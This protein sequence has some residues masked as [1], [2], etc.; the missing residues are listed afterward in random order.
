MN[1]SQT[2][3]QFYD[4]FFECVEKTLQ[5]IVNYIKKNDGTALSIAVLLLS[6]QQYNVFLAEMSYHMNIQMSQVEAFFFNRI[7][8]KYLYIHKQQ[9]V[10]YPQ[11]SR[12]TKI[13]QG[14]NIPFP[15]IENKQ[16]RF[17]NQV[18]DQQFQQQFPKALQSAVEIVS[19]VRVPSSYGHLCPVVQRVQ[20]RYSKFWEV[21]NRILPEFSETQLKQY[22]Q[23]VSAQGSQDFSTQCNSTI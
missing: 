13:N 21:M 10:S 14:N 23:K 8:S 9:Q 15:Q 18:Y 5:N 6:K 16:E 3:Q 7:S 2:F 22:F 11:N 4:R 1:C 20:Q 12:S 19:G 17:Q